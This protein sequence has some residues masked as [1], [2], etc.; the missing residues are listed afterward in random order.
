MLPRNDITVDVANAAMVPLARTSSYVRTHG[1]D[2]ISNTGR[3]IK[4]CFRRMGAIPWAHIK[5]TEERGEMD[6]WD[7]R[8]PDR[9]LA[10][11]AAPVFGHLRRLHTLHAASGRLGIFGTGG[12]SAVCAA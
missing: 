6:D 4:I 1:R 11:A 10:A 12:A 5:D 9:L 7:V 3:I 2:R 8:W